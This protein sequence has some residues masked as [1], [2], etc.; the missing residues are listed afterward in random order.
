MRILL[1]DDHA[2][3][4]NGLKRIFGELD[5]I[6]E[7]LEASDGVECLKVLEKTMVD[8][9]L[10]DINMPNMDGIECLKE[11]RKRWDDLKVLVLTQYDQ[12]RF[13]RQMFKQGANGYL[14]KTTSEEKLIEAFES[15]LSEEDPAWFENTGNGSLNGSDSE[16]PELGDREIEILGLICE[17]YNSKEIAEK[18]F[19]SKHTVDNHRASLLTKSRTKNIAGLV[20]WAILNKVV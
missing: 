19:I 9:V 18:L 11:I 7:V 20:K 10:L 8:A 15:M 2:L 14:L 3:F 12:K 13:V 16:G 6:D 5:S 4:R 1:V 17:Q